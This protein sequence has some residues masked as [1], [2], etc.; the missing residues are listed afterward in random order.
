MHHHRAMRSMAMVLRQL[1]ALDRRRGKGV[2]KVDVENVNVEL[3]PAVG[4]VAIEGP[5]LPSVPAPEGRPNRDRC[6]K[7]TASKPIGT[8][9]GAVAGSVAARVKKNAHSQG[10]ALEEA[11]L[12][13]Q[14]ATTGRRF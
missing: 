11:G 6:A 1:E 12:N 2:L 9:R 4:V 14:G 7:P 8:Q 10:G 13:R 5:E 3:G